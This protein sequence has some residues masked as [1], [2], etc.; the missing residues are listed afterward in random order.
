MLLAFRV[1]LEIRDCNLY[2]SVRTLVTSVY[3]SVLQQIKNKMC[4]YFVK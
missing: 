4:N 1:K 3:Q 2:V